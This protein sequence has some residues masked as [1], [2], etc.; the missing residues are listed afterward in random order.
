MPRINE[1]INGNQGT[2]DGQMVRNISYII[3]KV[4]ALPFADLEELFREVAEQPGYESDKTKSLK[5]YA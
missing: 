3:R 5:R 1:V 2:R 4:R